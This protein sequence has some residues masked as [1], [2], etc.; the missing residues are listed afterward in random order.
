MSDIPTVYTFERAYIREIEPAEE[1]RWSA[2]IHAHLTQWIAHLPRMFVA[3]LDGQIIGHCFWQ[4]DAAD[5]VLASL[6][7]VP[8]ARRQGLGRRLLRRFEQDAL[9]QGFTR[10]R[11]GVHENNPAQSLYERA[12]YHP[13]HSHGR[14]R[15]YEKPCA[16]DSD[17][18][19]PS[20][21]VQ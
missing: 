4:P 19:P 6:Y 2:A 12:G 8:A 1:P 15:D 21:W 5:A 17:R 20:N 14:Y 9:R 11:L 3:T 16:P 13:T 10:L 18:P 7:V